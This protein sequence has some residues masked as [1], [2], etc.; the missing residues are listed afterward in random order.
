MKESADVYA[1]FTL[2]K[3]ERGLKAE[4]LSMQQ[5]E[6]IY[7]VL[8]DNTQTSRHAID[9]RLFI[10]VIFA[11]FY[12]ILFAGRD[13]RRSSLR[14]AAFRLTRANRGFLKLAMVLMLSVF[15]VSVV[16][17]IFW[18]LYALKRYLGIDIF[19][20][21]HLSDFIPIGTSA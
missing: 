18:G 8:A 4:P 6:Q 17:S 15:S 3:I 19:P 2:A 11:N 10:P 7:A 9:V 16:L 13:R 1:R 12:L 21:A 20:N 14:L 5:R